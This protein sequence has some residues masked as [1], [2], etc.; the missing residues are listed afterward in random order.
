MSSATALSGSLR[1]FERT[2]GKG[3][4]G[5]VDIGLAAGLAF[6]V[7]EAEQS[8]SDNSDPFFV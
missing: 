6:G 7:N 5:T 4:D 2:L 3:D 8:I 1:V